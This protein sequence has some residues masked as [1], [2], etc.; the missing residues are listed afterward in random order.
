MSKNVIINEIFHIYFCLSKTIRVNIRYDP[1][2]CRCSWQIYKPWLQRAARRVLRVNT[3]LFRYFH[4][5]L[6]LIQA[7]DFRSKIRLNFSCWMPK[8]TRPYY[9]QLILQHVFTFGQVLYKKLRC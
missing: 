1:N 6:P 5:R 7:I 8:L 2:L 4:Q 3:L 9:S